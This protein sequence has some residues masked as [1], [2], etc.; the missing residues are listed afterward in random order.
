MARTPRA[1]PARGSCGSPPLRGRSRRAQSSPRPWPV[2]AGRGAAR[3]APRATSGAT[4]MKANSHARVTALVE[5]RRAMSRE[6]KWRPPTMISGVV[7][8][9]A[10]GGAATR[11]QPDRVGEAPASRTPPDSFRTSVERL[12]RAVEELTVLGAA[13]AGVGRPRRQ[14]RRRSARRSSGCRARRS[15]PRRRSPRPS[16]TPI[17]IKRWEARGRAWLPKRLRGRA[18]AAGR[19]APTP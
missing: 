3:R 10:G 2:G 13:A 4:P 16:R 9:P 19:R 15:Q 8:C 7:G 18:A 6:R 14:C 5:T 12:G 11:Q 1:G 17:A